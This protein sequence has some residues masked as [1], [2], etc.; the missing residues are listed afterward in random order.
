MKREEHMAVSWPDQTVLVSIL[1]QPADLARGHLHKIQHG[2]RTTFSTGGHQLHLCRTSQALGCCR[3][4]KNR[5]LLEELVQSAETNKLWLITA[6][7]RESGALWNFHKGDPK[8]CQN[9]VQGCMRVFE[10][11]SSARTKQSIRTNK[12]LLI[13]SQRS[14]HAVMWRCIA[15]ISQDQS[16]V[17]PSN[18][19]AKKEHTDKVKLVFAWKK[20]LLKAASLETSSYATWTRTRLLLAYGEVFFSRPLSAWL[21]TR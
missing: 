20:G 17:L 15:R 4:Q 21:E 5:I 10:T 8:A 6:D 9:D 7:R 11:G 13:W 3:P 19:L 12:D 14:G 16:L 18:Y 2:S 1:H